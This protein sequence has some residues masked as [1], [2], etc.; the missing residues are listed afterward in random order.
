MIK[1]NTKG[2]TEQEWQNLRSKMVN[3][4]MVGGSD[5]STLLGLNK[6]KSEINLYYQAIGINTLPNKMNGAMLHG[7]QLEKY[8]ADC[9][10]Y[11]DGTEEG[12]VANTLADNKIKKYRRINSILINPKYPS[13]FANV[14]AKITAHPVYGKKSGVLEVKTISGYSSDSYEAGIPPG[15]LI[16]LQHYLIVTGYKYGEIVYLKDGRDLGCLTFDADKEL[17][18]MI[19]EKAEAFQQRVRKARYEMAMNAKSDMEREQI[20]SYFEPDADSTLAF[21]EFVSERHKARDNEAVMQ[22]SPE[23]QNFAEKFMQHNSEIKEAE[24][25][26]MLYQN[27]L[28]QI[29]QNE[30]ASVMLLPSGG[31]ITWRKQ[32][33]VKL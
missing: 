32:F 5:A 3:Q 19:K 26:K 24:S 23:M 30:R 25:H 15:Y 2:L 8:V 4:G 1:H 16:Q 29:M 27:K 10:Q 18:D 7:K 21:N 17:Q 13:L 33:T 28:K 6:Y 12:W 9:W 22:G 14:D 20:A 11:F 31:K